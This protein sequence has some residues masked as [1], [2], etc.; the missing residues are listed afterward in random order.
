MHRIGVF[1]P[2]LAA[3][4]A[5]QTTVP[6]SLTGEIENAPN[7]FMVELVNR[8]GHGPPTRAFGHSGRFN[9]A[10]LDSGSYELRILDR[11]GGLL[12]TEY[13]EVGPSMPPAIIRLP[14][15]K[16]PARPVSG[17]V[18]LAELT[19]ERRASVDLLIAAARLRKKSD[20]EGAILKT[21]QAI[22][23][24]PAFAAPHLE[25]ANRY[26]GLNSPGDARRE[27]LR[28][29]ELDPKYVDAYTNLA[30][31]DL[32]LGDPIGAEQAALHAAALSPGSERATYLLALSLW[33][34]NRGPR[35]PVPASR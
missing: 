20:V 10:P 6:C 31:V 15:V 24:D 21:R 4:L 2:L 25:M 5:A 8:F 27:L 1:F 28:A 18:H 13:I 26:I 32:T 33:F 12:K 34:Q 30:I 16:P 29:I 22:E 17:V 23:R 11:D 9:V 3:A 35:P 7:Q 19:K 14:E